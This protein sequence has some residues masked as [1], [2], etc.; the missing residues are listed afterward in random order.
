MTKDKVANE[1]LVVVNGLKMLDR[2]IKLATQIPDEWVGVT[3]RPQEIRRRKS[4]KRQGRKFRRKCM[5]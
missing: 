4:K 3:V 5:R 1:L 2:G